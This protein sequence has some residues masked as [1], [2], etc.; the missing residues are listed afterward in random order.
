VRLAPRLRFPPRLVAMRAQLLRRVMPGR[1]PAAAADLC[2][3]TSGARLAPAP[4][5]GLSGT[6][7]RE[8]ANAAKSS[9]STVVEDRMEEP[10]IWPGADAAS[11]E[12]L[13]K[14]S[15]D[16]MPMATIL[17]ER[18]PILMKEPPAWET[19]FREYQMRNAEVAHQRNVYSS[20]DYRELE[21]LS[22]TAGSDQEDSGDASGEGGPKTLST[23]ILRADQTGDRRTAARALSNRLY[24]LVK[25]RDSLQPKRLIWQFPTVRYR[26]TKPSK[27]E[28]APPVPMTMR[29]TLIDGLISYVGD[30]VS[31]YP[32]GKAPVA[33]LCF[34]LPP[35][36]QQ[37]HDAYG[38]KVFFYRIQYLGGEIVLNRKRIADFAWVTKDELGDY[39][40]KATVRLRPPCL[41]L[42][43][44]RCSSLMCKRVH[45]CRHGE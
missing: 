28:G 21:E 45:N 20:K 30:D 33:H 23:R 10:L 32:V 18:Q 15:N 40:P 27:E 22:K 16:W 39:F 12:E 31:A 24:L 2:C 8:A 5:R 42:L 13:G 1:R 36:Q 6:R 37:K 34:E 44:Y 14:H 25:A 26:E 7:G 3:R 29:R 19:E 17:F 38:K 35:Q 9:G 11:A 41:L 4:R 43:L